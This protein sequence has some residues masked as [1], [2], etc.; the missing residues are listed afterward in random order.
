MQ[1]ILLDNIKILSHYNAYVNNEVT[2]R[3]K[4]TIEIH[5]II[6][7]VDIKDSEVKDLIDTATKEFYWLFDSVPSKIIVGITGYGKK[8]YFLPTNEGKLLTA[9]SPDIILDI[10]GSLTL[11]IREEIDA[12][13]R[14]I[15]DSV[16]KYY[17]EK[18]SEKTEKLYVDVN[19]LLASFRDTKKGE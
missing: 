12:Y 14:E 6:N 4:M 7:V 2:P 9:N 11:S 10:D 19:K 3:S 5:E 17:R 15:E 13:E 1:T 8:Y 16:A 18:Q